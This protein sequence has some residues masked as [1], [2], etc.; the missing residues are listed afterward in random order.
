MV[1]EFFQPRQVV[2]VH[3][4]LPFAAHNLASP[5]WEAMNGCVAGGNLHPLAVGTVCGAADQGS[6]LCKRQLHVPLG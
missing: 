3:T 4:G 1:A 6:S 2:M 5:S